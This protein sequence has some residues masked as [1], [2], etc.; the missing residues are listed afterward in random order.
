VGLRPNE[1]LKFQILSANIHALDE[2]LEA[3]KAEQRK[4]K[5]ALDELQAGVKPKTGRIAG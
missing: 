5:Q 4:G 2:I 1:T 3:A